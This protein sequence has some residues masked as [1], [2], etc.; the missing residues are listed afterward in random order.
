M[1]KR[2]FAALF[3]FLISSSGLAWAQCQPGA[4]VL[5]LENQ[6][7][8]VTAQ[9]QTPAGQTGAGQAVSLSADTGYFWFFSSSNVE[10]VVKVLNGCPV[11]NNFW[12]FAGGLTNV[13]V[14]LHVQDRATGAV[15]TYHNPQSTPFQPVQDTGAFDSCSAADRA[16][17]TPAGALSF[18][19]I[20]DAVARAA[21][22]AGDSALCLNGGRYRVSASWATDNAA[23]NGHAVG[24]TGDTGYFWFFSPSNLEMIVKVLDGCAVN[25]NVWV[26]AGGLT[27]VE[28]SLRVEDTVTGSVTN[29]HNP[30]TTAFQPIQ[31]TEAFASCGGNGQLEPP[32]DHTV[33]PL[34]VLRVEPPQPAGGQVATA[35]V[36]AQGASSIH[37][38][39]TG[40]AC[41]GFSDHSATGSQLTT[42]QTVGSFG[43]CRL[44]AQVIRGGVTQTYNTSFTVAPVDLALPAVE[45]LNGV[46]NPGDLPPATSGVPTPDIAAIAAPGT[47]LPGST[48]EL[49]ISL[50]DPTL[51]AGVNRIQVKVPTAAGFNGF[52]EAPVSHD[53]NVLVAQIRLDSDFFT[54]S[55][56]QARK[57]F[58][59][60]KSVADGPFDVVVQ[61]VDFFGRIGRSLISTFTAQ[62]AGSNDVQVSLSWDTL[63]DVDLHVVEPSPG[64]EIFWLNRTSATTGGTLDVD[65]NAG[66]GID[67]INNENITWPNGAPLHGE[68]IVR[69]D[70]WSACGGQPANYTVTTRV[71]GEI[72]TFH[73]SFSPDEADEGDF[74]AGVEIT[75]F[76]P[77]CSFRVRGKA[78][79]EDRQQTSS[80]LSPTKTKLPI[81]FAKVEVR[82]ASDDQVLGKDSTKQDGTFDVRFQNSGEDGYYVAVLTD[83]E[84][85]MVQQT[86]RN[87]AQKIYSARSVGTVSEAAEPDKT[88]LAI[89]ALESD[90]SGPAFNIFDMGVTGALF[91]RSR[92]GSSPPL[93]NWLWTKGDIGDCGGHPVSCY[94]S[95]KAQIS[96][97]SIDDDPDQYDDLVLLHEFGHMWQH[98]QSRNDSHGGSHSAT[99]QIDPLLAWAEGSATFFGSFVKGIPFYID[100]VKSGI[101]NY[102]NLESPDTSIPSGTSDQTQNGR[103]SETRLTAILWDLADSTNETGDTVSAVDAVFAA[104]SYLKGAFADRGVAGADLVDFLD[105]WFCKGFGQRGDA[106]S[107]VQGI[108][109]GLH[110]FPYDFATLP[111]CN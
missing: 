84:S 49:R 16:E 38:I 69:V 11:N 52:F 7:F 93:L 63:T 39:A 43:D 67:G 44:T 105:G 100:T 26:F 33:E 32:K 37:L 54:R 61:L 46:F 70:Y 79:Y 8:Q 4:T 72:K 98:L 87:N 86:V 102:L 1:S 27:N 47:L 68:H 95:S 48:V 77:N 99:E 90:D 89:L 85:D 111:S 97:L 73:G 59:T 104:A 40:Q 92:Y 81:R 109:V 45:L 41:G 58:A 96:V 88:D 107:G 56:E 108:V 60:Q 106:T 75:R 64:E 30:R 103:L 6:R 17:A 5:C 36:D 14:V 55:S 51:A 82:R 53:G 21:C 57:R 42:A 78:E 91:Y 74:G 12:V 110:G 31:D 101:G 50:T 15:R 19:S 29:Y 2:I 34:P 62:P 83:Q 80:G 18:P 23:G 24:L 28:V 3:F 9:W 25:Q 22:Q 65:S 94:D 35:I 20:S 71:C 13:D 76:T 10:L 66:C